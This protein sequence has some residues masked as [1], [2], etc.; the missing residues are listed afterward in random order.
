MWMTSRFPEG[1]SALQ[2]CC[3]GLLH[4]VRESLFADST[5]NWGMN[6]TNRRT[7]PEEKGGASRS[8]MSTGFCYR[9]PH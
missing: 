9:V 3:Y 2:G 7:L 4:I 8:S 1:L 5:V 6:R